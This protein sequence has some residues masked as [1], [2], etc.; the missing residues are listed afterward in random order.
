M[1]RAYDAATKD[2][3]NY[4][5][6]AVNQAAQLED[7]MSRD[8]LRARARD[9]ERNS[10]I[11]N[12]TIAAL[13]RNVVGSGLRVQA[14]IKENEELNRQIEDLW[15]RWCLPYH[16]DAQQ[17]LS[18]DEICRLVVR[19]LYVDGGILL[20]KRY[21]PGRVIPFCLQVLE[22]DEIDTT[23]FSPRKKGNTV[24]DGIELNRYGQREG[25][26]IR[27]YGLDGNQ[28]MES[29]FLESSEVIY[30]WKK[31]RPSQRREV[32]RFASSLARVRDIDGI[33]EAVSMKERISACL[34]VFI[35]KV[36]PGPGDAGRGS[37]LKDARSGYDGKMLTP[38]LVT[39]L[40]PGDDIA[41]V[42]PPNQGSG[43][44]E[45]ARLQQRLVASG[46]GLSYESTA[47]DLSGVNYS[48]AR[49]G[50]I[51]DD[52]T[53][54][55]ERKSLI[56]HVLR[57]VYNTFIVS[58]VIS[59]ALV[60]PDF[61]AR[62]QE[63]LRHEWVPPGRKWIDPLREAKADEVAVLQRLKTRAQLAAE[64]G[65]DWREDL[66]QMAVELDYM[67]TLG[68]IG[69]GGNDKATAAPWAGNAK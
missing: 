51:E 28:Q 2:R 27:Q 20:V 21:V 56:Q 8:M 6:R 65:R 29:V 14:R 25:I 4:G 34:A 52:T 36:R 30:Y 22:V 58:A 47:R 24:V 48:A 16:C 31:T 62:K 45:Y 54:G 17:D 33:L 66:E 13:E 7:G 64:A 38:G 46:Q 1:Q 18:W 44:S 55:I 61:W 68:L 19:R 59:G 10:D 60:I 43:A 12:G 3:L 53:Y 9:L 41:A 50:L 57:E 49:Q 35:K 67:R 15:E 23:R 26:W 11:L 39:E 32:S 69:G 40:E 42:T 5:W 63:Y 37:R